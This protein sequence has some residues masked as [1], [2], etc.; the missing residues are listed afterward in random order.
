MHQ[1]LADQEGLESGGA[2]A[3]YVGRGM[4][5]AFRNLDDAGGDASRQAEGSIE[6]HLKR[7]QIAGVDSN[8]IRATFQGQVDFGLVMRFD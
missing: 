1:V 8:E 5:S 7:L 4:D 3:Y 2:E 6:R